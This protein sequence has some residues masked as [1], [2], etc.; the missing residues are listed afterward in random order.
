M[1][2]S[3]NST[4]NRQAKKARLHLSYMQPLTYDIVQVRD[5]SSKTVANEAFL[6]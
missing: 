4:F 1:R 3:P 2:D 5:D 6:L